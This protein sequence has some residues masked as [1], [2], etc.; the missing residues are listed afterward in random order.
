[1]GDPLSSSVF[2]GINTAFKLAEFGLSLNEASEENLV[3][4]RLIQRVRKD[5]AEAIRER[6][7]K[8]TT[9]DATPLKKEWIDEIINDTDAALF[10][11]GKLV[12]SGR[13]DGEHGRSMTLRHRFEWVMGKKESFLSKQSLLA[14]CH[15]SPSN[16]I[17]YM[18]QLPTTYSAPLSP[19]SPP[20]Y[21]SA[22][23]Q[24]RAEFSFRSQSARRPKPKPEYVLPA[25]ANE[26]FVSGFSGK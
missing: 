3:F 4:C 16:A 6:G 9:L 15:Q 5:R 17:V 1:M 18:Q 22:D 19:S 11:I 24:E 2:A 13:A 21:W 25:H 7:E 8:A 14:T 26:S 23:E 12:E 20:S 10:T